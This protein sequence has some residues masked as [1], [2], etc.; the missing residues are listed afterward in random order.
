MSNMFVWRFSLRNGSASGGA[1]REI[2]RDAV[3]AVAQAGRLRAVVEDVA[4]MAAATAA[5]HFG[6]HGAEREVR[7]RRDGLVERRPEARPAGM[8]VEFRARRKQVEPAAGA[9][10]APRAMLV[11]ERTRVRAFGAFVTQHV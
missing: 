8:A 7:A 5:M 6:A 1:G 2:H 10:K 3:H 11:V 9:G 4:E